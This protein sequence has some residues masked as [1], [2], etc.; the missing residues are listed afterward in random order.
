MENNQ[1]DKGLRLALEA[2]KKHQGQK[3]S[4]GVA[5]E[6]LKGKI[7]APAV[8]DKAPEP[9]GHGQLVFPQDTNISLM[10][11][12]RQD[13]KNYFPFFTSRQSLEKWNPKAQCLVLTFDQFMPFVQM[14]GN[15]IDG[16][17]LD[18]E[19]L[20]ITLDSGFLKQL[21]KI[22]MRGLSANRIAKGDKITVRNPG[23]DGKYLGNVLAKAAE[24]LP[25]IRS[26]VLKER[27]MP[28]NSAHWFIIVDAEKEDP[29]LFSKLSAEG[30]R[31]ANGK[32]M[33][34]MFASAELGRK[35]MNDSEPVYTKTLQA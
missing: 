23:D 30:S 32:D 2:L 33:E 6:M 21:E 4:A 19:D 17:I 9:D 18:P 16:V 25:E 12:A 29:V 31:L 28:D 22:R 11:M 35:I 24:G 1:F 15:E 27:L 3:E 14:A 8:W 7:L 13:G 10:V 26:I 34:F 5:A 20:D